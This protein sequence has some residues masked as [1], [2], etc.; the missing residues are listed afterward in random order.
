MDFSRERTS[1]AFHF[2]GSFIEFFTGDV[3]KK[4]FFLELLE[5]NIGP[6]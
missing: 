5:I 6:W 3:V 2:Y 1:S 4:V